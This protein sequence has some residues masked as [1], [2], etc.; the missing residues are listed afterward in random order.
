[1]A[2]YVINEWFWADLRGDNGKVKLTESFELLIRFGSSPHQMVIAVGSAF[3]DKAWGLCN[4]A[5][6][7]ARMFML[8][9]RQD[10]ER[11]LLLH[12]DS[13]APFPE[14]LLSK[15]KPAD[16]YLVQTCLAVPESILVTTDQPLLE[17]VTAYGIPCLYRNDFMQLV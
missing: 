5:P 17:A 6:G 7:I 2:S 10:S 14:E 11:C 13:W 9:I 12:R 8:T 3:D 1:V 15:V 4:A 16:R